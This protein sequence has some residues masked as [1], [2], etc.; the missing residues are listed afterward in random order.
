MTTYQVSHG[1]RFDLTVKWKAGKSNYVDT[2]KDI[3]CAD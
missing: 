2:I 1:S 3:R